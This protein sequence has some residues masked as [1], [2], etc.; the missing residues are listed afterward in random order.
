MKKKSLSVKKK[1]HNNFILDNLKFSKI[2]HIYKEF[3]S[4]LDIYLN[5]KNIAIG[6]SG[7][8]DSLSLCYFAKC[9]ALKNNIK[10]YFYIVDHKIR[11]NST[12]EALKVKSIL[13]P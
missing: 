2:K 11:K 8:P 13:K 6:V 1:N 7:G 3:E 5:D 9:Y 10:L 4:T 12:S